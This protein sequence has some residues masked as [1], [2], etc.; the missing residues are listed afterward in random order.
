MR[1]FIDEGT[2]EKST[3]VVKTEEINTA[4]LKISA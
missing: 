2:D 4:V 3:I 1:V